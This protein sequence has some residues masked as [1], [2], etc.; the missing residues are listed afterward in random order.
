MK[1]WI[2]IL[3][4]LVIAFWNCIIVTS[5]VLKVRIFD[6]ETNRLT[7]ARVHLRNE[8]NTFIAPEGNLL[9]YTMKGD[10]YFYADGAFRIK[11][12][13]GTYTMTLAKGVEY[14]VS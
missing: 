6:A 2:F 13:P 8:D 4:I 5:E 3:G 12:P 9:R 11:V 14:S 10:G 1:R 7:A